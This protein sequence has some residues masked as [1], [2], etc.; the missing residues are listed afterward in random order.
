MVETLQGAPTQGDARDYDVRS[1]VLES[2][3]GATL[4]EVADRA[5]FLPPSTNALFEGGVVE[6]ALEPLRAEQRE[7]L[8]F[9]RMQSVAIAPIAGAL[10]CHVQTQW[11]V[12]TFSREKVCG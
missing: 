11:S 5:S 6:L 4:V 2:G 3:Q 1:D 10:W 9:G 12:R 7:R 8:Q